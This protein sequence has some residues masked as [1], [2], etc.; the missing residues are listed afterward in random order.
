[1]KYPFTVCVLLH[2]MLFTFSTSCKNDKEG[3]TPQP[4]ARTFLKQSDLACR[5][6]KITDISASGTATPSVATFEYD[7]QGRMIKQTYSS[8]DFTQY[9]YNNLDQI[10]RVLI[11]RNDNTTHPY[12]TITNE[13]DD[14]GR[15][16]KSTVNGLFEP[17]AYLVHHD[18]KGNRVKVEVLGSVAGRVINT[19]SYKYKDGN[20]IESVEEGFNNNV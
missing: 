5:V 18:G 12:E 17:V 14:K 13:Y 9:E 1:M 10:V 2:L 6:L 4:Q 16:V 7:N 11:Y 15:W 3:S 19:Y 20:L 8:G